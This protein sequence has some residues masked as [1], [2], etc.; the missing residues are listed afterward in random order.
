MTCMQNNIYAWVI[1]VLPVLATES[2]LKRWHFKPS[3][4]SSLAEYIGNLIS[5]AYVKYLLIPWH[6]HL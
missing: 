6:I 2:S 1:T 3:L 4:A 5:E